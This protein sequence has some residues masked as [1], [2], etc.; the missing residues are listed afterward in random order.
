M[1]RK[2]RRSTMMEDSRN[3]STMTI[4]S[5]SD[6][7]TIKDRRRR[8]VRSMSSSWVTRL[9]SWWNR[10]NRKS[11][12]NIIYS[13]DVNYNY[14]KIYR[15]QIDCR[16][17]V[18]LLNSQQYSCSSFRTQNSRNI[19]NPHSSI[20]PTHSISLAFNQRAIFGSLW[21]INN[22]I[23]LQNHLIKLK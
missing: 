22:V 4:D 7:V 2:E 5:R 3:S 23:K 18:Q 16:Q 10:T 9:V 20:V 12:E 17:S 11:D 19:D 8:V 21:Q 15:K 1:T 13:V 6:R 14:L